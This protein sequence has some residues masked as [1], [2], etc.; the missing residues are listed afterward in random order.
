MLRRHRRRSALL[1]DGSAPFVEKQHCLPALL[2][3][4]RGGNEHGG[5]IGSSV[6]V[7]SRAWTLMWS[8]ST[9]MWRL[10]RSRMK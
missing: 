8:T 5:R 4:V 2:V 3:V 1:V 9:I 6:S 7:C 10:I